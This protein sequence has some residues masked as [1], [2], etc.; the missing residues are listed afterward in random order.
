MGSTV[1]FRLHLTGDAADHHQF[2]GYDG[3]TSLAGFAWTLALVTNYAETGKLRQ[4]GEF[5]GRDA[6]QANF[7]RQGSIIA[8]FS[9]WLGED[10][11]IVL[12]LGSI[13]GASAGTFLCDLVQRVIA[14][15]LGDNEAVTNPL[16]QRLL[17]KRGGEV[18]ALVAKVEPSVRQSHQVI[19]NGATKMRILGGHNVLGT[20]DRDTQEYIKA[21]IPDDTIRAGSFSVGAYDV[22][23]G[24]GRVYDS[25]LGKMV[26]ITMTKD[27]RERFGYIFSWALDQYANKTGGKVR[28]EYTRILAVDGTPKRYIVREAERRPVLGE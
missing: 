26:T 17:E 20:Y 5:P 28:M 12:G 9:V 15:N 18:E 3:F 10:P 24:H 23:S 6:V 11:S 22:N 25:K 13:A 8:D 21:N 1:P 27:V 2:Q 16:L 4:R 19:G 7:P 14:R